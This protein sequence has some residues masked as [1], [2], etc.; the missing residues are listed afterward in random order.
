MASRKLAKAPSLQL[1]LP[2]GQ[3]IQTT[4]LLLLLTAARVKNKPQLQGNPVS[5]PYPNSALP[6]IL[7]GEN[8]LPEGKPGQRE[9]V[10]G[11]QKPGVLLCSTNLSILTK[12]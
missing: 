12:K 2:Q 7:A 9:H 8:G 1:S 3:A 6:S 5:L 4:Q 11:P 10:E